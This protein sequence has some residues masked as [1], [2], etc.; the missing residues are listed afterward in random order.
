MNEFQLTLT[1]EERQCL[2]DLLKTVLK[3]T[4]VEEHRTRTPIY[5]EVVLLKET[6]IADLLN[7]LAQSPE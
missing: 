2:V 7:K 6:I 4:R 5:R 1:V 3:E